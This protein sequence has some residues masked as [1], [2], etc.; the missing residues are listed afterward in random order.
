MKRIK[1]IIQTVRLCVISKRQIRIAAAVLMGASVACNQPAGVNDQTAVFEKT[2]SPVYREFNSTAWQPVAKPSGPTP[3]QTGSWNTKTKR[4]SKQIS[5][6]L[7]LS[8]PGNLV[9]L[10]KGVD[11]YVSQRTTQFHVE[12]DLPQTLTGNEASTHTLWMYNC[13]KRHGELHVWLFPFPDGNE[14]AFAVYQFEEP[15]K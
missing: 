9:Q 14:V 1:T 15:L 11:S 12:E 4:G 7:R 6:V 2:F 10:L 13:G 8:A 5:G 3:K